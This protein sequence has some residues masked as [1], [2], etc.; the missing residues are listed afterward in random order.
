[1][2]G[3]QYSER[4]SDECESERGYATPGEASCSERKDLSALSH[5][6]TS[7]CG[8]SLALTISW[9]GQVSRLGQLPCDG[10]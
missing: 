10:C 2:I 1:M 7:G 8:N 4:Q 5:V 3:V 9:A 6:P